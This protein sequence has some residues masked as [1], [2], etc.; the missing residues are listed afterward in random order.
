MGELVLTG[1]DAMVRELTL[2]A[3][4]GFLVG[5]IGDLI[6]DLAWL[7]H[8]LRHGTTRRPISTRSAIAGTSVAI[9]STEAWIVG[10]RSSAAPDRL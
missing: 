5:G 8:R 9:S 7:G 6:V 4:V 2:F 10:S 1:L 3:A